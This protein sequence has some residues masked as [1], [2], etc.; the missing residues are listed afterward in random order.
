[1]NRL[2]GKILEVKKLS[3]SYLG[4][5][6]LDDFSYSFLRGEK[7]GIIGANGV[8]KSSFLNL[9]TGIE[10]ADS[11]SI[12]SGETIVFGFYKQ[13]GI[14]LED[15]K[16][17]IDVVKDIAEI[18]LLNDGKSLTASQFLQHFMFPPEMQYSFVS[19]LSGGERRRLY[20]LTVLIKNPNFL[21]LDEPTNDLDI[22]TLNKIED[23]LSGFG[24]CLI[25]ATHDRYF[26]DRLVDH[27]FVFKGEGEI[28]DFTG[29]YTDYRIAL[30]RKYELDNSVDSLQKN[31]KKSIPNANSPEKKKLNYK[32]KQEFERLEK[33]IAT[34]EK[35]KTSLEA[36]LNSG[37]NNYEKLQE[38]SLR[39]SEIIIL[40]DV[41]V[42]RWLE[43]DELSS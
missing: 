21:I 34:L 30:E 28:S 32:D 35:E 9:I 1:M 39:I 5:K 41:K 40:L 25:L 3:K 22:I 14:I 20:L 12:E 19:K 17:V 29:S 43:L 4:I 18:I 15:D 24:G 33:E 7:I 38:V 16:R 13:D 23:F 6:I 10:S 36:K 11:G 8:G 37:E 31:L 2:G 42:I 27:I 26:L